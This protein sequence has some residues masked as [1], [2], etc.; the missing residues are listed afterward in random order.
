MSTD[1]KLR[2]QN[3]KLSIVIK[4]NLRGR[5]MIFFFFTFDGS[6]IKQCDVVFDMLIPYGICFYD[7]TL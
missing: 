3:E 1:K 7:Q 4:S 6:Y 2:V 5:G